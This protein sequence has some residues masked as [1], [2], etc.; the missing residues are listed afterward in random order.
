MNFYYDQILG[1]QVSFGFH[2]FLIDFDVLPIDNF[3]FDDWYSSL[4]TKGIN[5]VNSTEN[6]NDIKTICNI[7]SQFLR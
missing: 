3:S 7:T 5:F 6:I 1:L 2:G 4:V